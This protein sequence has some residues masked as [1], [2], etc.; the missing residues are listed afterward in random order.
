METMET[1]EQKETLAVVELTENNMLHLPDNLVREFR[2]GER[3]VVLRYGDT[4]LL[5]RI[6][7]PRITDIVA[8]TP[9]EEPPLTMEE[10]NEIVHEVRRQYAREQGLKLEISITES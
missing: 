7:F 8:Q 10:I 3:F 1:T 9:S 6:S 4:I 5:K 2:T